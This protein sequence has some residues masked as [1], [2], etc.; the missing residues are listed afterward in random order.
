MFTTTLTAEEALVGFGKG[1]DCSQAVFAEFAPQFENG[2]D[3][4]TALKIAAIFGGGMLEGD[5]CGAVSG[6]LMALGLKY[7][8][9]DKVDSVK[10][11]VM[12]RKAMEFKTK[13]AEKYGSCLCKEMLGYKIPEEMDKIMAENKFGTVCCN[14]VADACE[15]V[16]E[17]L[18]SDEE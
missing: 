1:V 17:I 15:L 12:T 18:N 6:A 11:N 16:A 3:R 8:Q 5:T 13:F 7:G 2:V 4:E 9:G 14:A 10:K